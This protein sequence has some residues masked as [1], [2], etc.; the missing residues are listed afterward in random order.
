MCKVRWLTHDHPAVL[1]GPWTEEE[2]QGLEH[3]VSEAVREPK[4]LNP[5]ESLF[6]VP[7]LGTGDDEVEAKD[8]DWEL[9]AQFLGV[10]PPSLPLN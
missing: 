5:T 8:V 4:V 1:R 3:A 7:E 6:G 2:R 10:G 9:V